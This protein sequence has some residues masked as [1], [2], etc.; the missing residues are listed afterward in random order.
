MNNKEMNSKQ[1]QMSLSSSGVDISIEISKCMWREQSESGWV[2]GNSTKRR[3]AS[4]VVPS[5]MKYTV[6]ILGCIYT[7]RSTIYFCGE[8]PVRCNV[9]YKFDDGRQ[10]LE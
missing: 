4:K 2:L 10:C 9:Y 6:C 3:L 1:S 8:E 5:H 7:Y